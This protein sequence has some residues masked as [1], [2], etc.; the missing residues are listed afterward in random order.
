MQVNIRFVGG[1]MK[2]DFNY[3][4]TRRFH[5]CLAYTCP[6]HLMN[7]TVW[8]TYN[9]YIVFSR[10]AVN[11][12]K[13]NDRIQSWHSCVCSK[14]ESFSLSGT[15]VLQHVVTGRHQRLL[16]LPIQRNICPKEQVGLCVILQGSVILFI[17]YYAF[18][19][20]LVVHITNTF[21]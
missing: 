6:I 17:W 20:R 18:C 5:T 19:R 3:R 9:A 12:M 1:I 13:S 2:L 10:Q 21:E 8:L 11:Q 14:I 16:T 4:V 15:A 7:K